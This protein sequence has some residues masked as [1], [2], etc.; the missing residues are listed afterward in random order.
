MLTALQPTLDAISPKFELGLKTLKA[1]LPEEMTNLKAKISNQD[2]KIA[3]QQA[4]LRSSPTP[5]VNRLTPLDIALPE[6]SSLPPRPL[7]I[8]KP[9]GTINQAPLSSS[10]RQSLH[11]V[12]TTVSSKK[13][14][15]I[16]APPTDAQITKMA[17]S[18]STKTTSHIYPHSERGIVIEFEKLLRLPTVL[19]CNSAR[20]V[21]NK[22]L[23]D[24][25]D[26]FAPPFVNARFRE[27]ISRYNPPNEEQLRI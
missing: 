13:N 25:K 19:A 2:S 24:R 8:H 15:A 21:V 7:A 10:P 20:H 17:K 23:I 3:A 22:M 9:V 6:T 4:R 12:W 16:K 14:A 11:S 1:D 26:V 18:S 5:A 27:I